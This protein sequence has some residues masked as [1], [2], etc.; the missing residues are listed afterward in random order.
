MSETSGHHFATM[1]TTPPCNV[2]KNR[3]CYDTAIM[4]LNRTFVELMWPVIFMMTVFMF[5][6]AFGNSVVL[7]MYAR[8]RQG[9]T[10]VF[11]LLLAGID[12]LACLVIHPYVLY[13]LF[14][15][16]DQTWNITCKIFEFFIHVTLAVSGL[17][18]LLV[19]IDRYL[20]ICHPVR[21]LVFDRHVTKGISAISVISI[22]FSL[23]LFE[24]YGAAPN[25][26][27]YQGTM[28]KTFQCHYQVKYQTSA[29]LMGFGAFV[30]FIFLSEVIAMVFLYKNVAV[31]A[32]RR[33]KSVMPLSN[34]PSLGGTKPTSGSKSRL[35]FN[36]NLTR[37][38]SSHTS[39][40]QLSPASLSPDAQQDKSI[41]FSVTNHAF[42]PGKSQDR[43]YGTLNVESRLQANQGVTNMKLQD[44]AQTNRLNKSLNFSSR[45][46]AAKILFLV[47]AVYFLSWMPF[48]VLRLAY[49]LNRNFWDDDSDTKKVMELLLNHI[50]YLNNAANPIIYTM[51]NQTFRQ[52][53]KQLFI[54]HLRH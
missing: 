29:V 20:A 6:G 49:I 13:K 21:Y 23:P 40:V 46:K 43:L 54:R 4:E 45:L 37:S 31:T 14:N 11:I 47:T 1:N 10:H 33:R 22:L 53:C 7:F 39:P 19:A 48:F 17:T 9:T 12:W 36:P 2:D 5:V 25:D 28:V 41:I 35:P 8:K 24:F 18:L 34:V 52:E 51:I 50:F 44:I 30:M 27:V 26:T 15:N 32:Y 38:L 42:Q 16:Y 3:T